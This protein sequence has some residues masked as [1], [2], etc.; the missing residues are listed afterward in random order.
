VQT[1]GLERTCEGK[2][3]QS[4]CDE[5]AK[6]QMDQANGAKQGNRAHFGIVNRNTTQLVLYRA[7]LL[8]IHQV[9]RYLHTFFAQVARMGLVR[10]VRPAVF[11]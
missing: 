11:A 8:N 3:Q 5:D 4:R 1:E 6:I 2:E 7:G 10:Q 9:E